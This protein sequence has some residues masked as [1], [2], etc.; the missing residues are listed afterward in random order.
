MLDRAET[1]P[2]PAGASGPSGVLAPLPWA[3]LLLLAVL[4]T[5]LGA[6]MALLDLE[7]TRDVH[8]GLMHTGPDGPAAEL[9]A[10]DFP[11]QP[12]FT[13]GEHDGPMFYAVARDPFD[14]DRAAESLDRPRY[15]LQHPLFSWLAWVGSPSGGG[16]PLARSFFAVG[17]LALVA[18]GVAMGALSHTL[19]GPIWLAVLFPILPGAIMS[20]RITVADAL[21]VALMLAAL[22]ASLR[23]RTTFAVVLAVGAVLTKEPMILAFGGLALWRR[24]HPGWLLVGTPVAVAGLW[25]LFLRWRVESPGGEVIEFGLPFA[26]LWEG[27]QYWAEGGS[28]LAMLAAVAALGLGVAT[29][30]RRRLDHPLSIAVGAYL[31]FV[32]LLTPTVLALERNGTRMTMPLLALAIVAMVAPRGATNLPSS[33]RRPPLALPGRASPASQDRRSQETSRAGPE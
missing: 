16:E 4:G 15:R 20:L 14:L 5:V 29:L 31:A 6:S 2:A 12:Q 1:E 30:V 13:E 32:L 8:G 25:A 28:P 19:R 3:R 7:R 27:V 11:D 18:G 33:L 21:G 24:D 9:F 26:G 10:R 23:G 22:A 17:V